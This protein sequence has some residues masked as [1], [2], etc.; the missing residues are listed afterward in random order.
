MPQYGCKQ[1]VLQK[2]ALE[3][4]HSRGRVGHHE[5]GDFICEFKPAILTYDFY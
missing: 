4:I 5:E 1:H 3:R 2:W